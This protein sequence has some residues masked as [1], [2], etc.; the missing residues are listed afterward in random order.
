MSTNDVVLTESVAPPLDG[1]EKKSDQQLKEQFHELVRDMFA[2]DEKAPWCQFTILGM[3][4]LVADIPDLKMIRKAR[5]ATEHPEADVA[6]D[7]HQLLSEYEDVI[8]G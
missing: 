6:R 8:G 7:E 2:F 4:L 1:E 3:G 5:E